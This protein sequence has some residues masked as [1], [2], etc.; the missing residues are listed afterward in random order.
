MSIQ[1]YNW[2]ELVFPNKFHTIG[3]I[4]VAK[5]A[6]AVNFS[7]EISRRKEKPKRKRL[8]EASFPSLTLEKKL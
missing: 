2:N 8:R 7:H 4:S 5:N 3:S 6:K 1:N